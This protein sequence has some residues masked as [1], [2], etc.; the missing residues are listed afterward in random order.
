MEH[1]GQSTAAVQPG[2]AFYLPQPDE[3][4]SSQRSKDRSRMSR[5]LPFC[6]QRATFSPTAR[7]YFQTKW[8]QK[9]YEV[10]ESHCLPRR[11]RDFDTNFG[12]IFS[13]IHRKHVCSLIQEFNE[14]A[15]IDDLNA[16]NLMLLELEQIINEL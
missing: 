8:S 9:N 11:I 14:N 1:S 7:T 15:F 12:Y 16:L 6:R 2:T 10:A 3:R 13:D 4:K 5:M